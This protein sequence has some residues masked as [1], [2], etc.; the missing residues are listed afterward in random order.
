M[1]NPTSNS[2][3]PGASRGTRSAGSKTGSTTRA[4]SSA[5]QDHESAI[6]L[7]TQNWS[8]VPKTGKPSLTLLTAALRHAADYAG[9]Q[10]SVDMFLALAF[11]S[12]TVA[13]E[14]Q[15]DHV[16][17]ALVEHTRDAVEQ[18]IMA[19]SEQVATASAEAA[20]DTMERAQ[21]KVSKELAE[22]RQEME[23][24]KTVWEEGMKNG[25]AH[26]LERDTQGSSPAHLSYAEAARFRQEPV[27]QKA[28]AQSRQ[29]LIEG[30]DRNAMNGEILNENELVQRANLAFDH[31]TIPRE[32]I[33]EGLRFTNVKILARGG[34]L[35]EVNE[36]KGATWLQRPDVRAAFMKAFA[37]TGG[38]IKDRAYMLVF[39]TVPTR[40]KPEHAAHQKDFR[41]YNAGVGEQVQEMRWIKSAERRRPGQVRAAMFISFTDIDAANRAIDRG[42]IFCGQRVYGRKWRPEPKRCFK[43]HRIEAGHFAAACTQRQEVCGTCGEVGAGHPTMQCPVQ[44]RDNMWC[45][46]CGSSGHPT[47]DKDCPSSLRAQAQIVKR[48]PGLLYRHFPKM[49][50]LST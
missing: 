30:I 18:A 32:E 11:Y 8:L 41:D 43:C 47:W 44:N 24:M 10:T 1:A 6:K 39:D 40:F 33:P 4:T 48:N 21:E 12:E 16:A 5:V 38:T 15:G 42:L 14:I 17:S 46:N 7:L 25:R 3:P 2:T 22:M 45:Q 31:M 50:D 13:L 37:P 23:R 9:G 35:Y 29:I 34:L 26:T 49:N 20:A 36:S 28:H 19:A 27:L